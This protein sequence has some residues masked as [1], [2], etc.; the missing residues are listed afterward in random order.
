MG[1]T[2]ANYS[3]LLQQ[4]LPQGIA[5]PRD[6]DSTLAQ[7]LSAVAVEFSRIDARA[8]SL[9]DAVMPSAASELLEDWERV[10]GLPDPCLVGQTQTLQLRGDA[11][12][13]KL[14][15]TGGQSI[16]YF[17][18]IAADLGFT[19]TIDEFRPFRAG[20]AVA[21]DSLTNGDWAHTWRVNGPEATVRHFAAGLSTAG[22][23]LAEW[24]NE[25]LECR[26]GALKPA[27]TVLLFAYPQVFDMMSLFANGEEG[28]FYD[29]AVEGSMFT[30]F[31]G[32]VV[33]VNENDAIANIHDLSGNGYH[34]TKA[35]TGQ[36][37]K[38]ILSAN[39]YRRRVDYDVLD[40]AL[41]L[42]LPD[43]GNNCT[44]ARARPGLGCVIT[45][46][47]GIHG[48]QSDNTDFVS[49]LILDRPFTQIEA[50]GVRLRFKQRS[51]VTDQFNVPY[52]DDP[53]EILD[54]FHS[55]G[56]PNKPIIVMVH[57]GF[58]RTGS[59][60]SPNVIKAKLQH[61][62]PKGFTFV[63]VNYNLDVGTDPLDQCRSVA[64]ALAWVQSQASSWG[65]NPDNI[66]MMGH[67]AGAH[68]VALMT[69]K[70]AYREEF[71]VKPWLGTVIIDSAAYNLNYIML[72]P[73]HL[74][75][76]NEPWGS[77]PAHWAAGSP[78]LQLDCTPAPMFLITST[79]TNPGEA[80]GFAGP[81]R[82]AI[83]ARG[84]VA[85]IYPTAYI[86]E[87]TNSQLGLPNPYTADVDD[88]IASIGLSTD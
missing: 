4:L 65:C 83:V 33:L 54:V 6:S 43:L 63:S 44:I 34:G 28:L 79:D 41:T 55:S 77:D 56:H 39:N 75:G 7:F 19:V 35:A 32:T 14:A 85:T 84:G 13:A 18:A 17:I 21:G 72:N 48:N 49:L 52:G 73:S 78:T 46:G 53:A 82:D 59:K 71:G 8:A 10:A 3:R 66:V 2:E 12:V 51:G 23:S 42:P 88:F 38:M 58:W 62:I 22:Q 87:E 57:G 86:H 76:Y 61:W 9:V 26:L 81:F 20:I 27:H 1:L 25:L 30:D 47:V 37:P 80:D 67:S 68:L 5:W 36:R 45:S 24:G 69:A 70:T 60:Q 40:D 31:A 15:G 50:D 74:A 64:K 16:A 29:A 11:L